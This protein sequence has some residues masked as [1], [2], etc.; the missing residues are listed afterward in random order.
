MTVLAGDGVTVLDG[1]QRMIEQATSATALPESPLLLVAIALAVALVLVV[2]RAIW[3]ISGHVV[4][5]VHELGHGFAGLLT[6]RR[7]VSIRLSGNHA[8]VTTSKGTA[9]SVPWTTFW[10]YPVPALVGAALVLAGMSGWAGAALAAATAILLLSLLFMRG[11]LAWL[12]TPLT[13]LLAAVLLAAAPDPWL[14]S[15]VVGIG[16]FLVCGAVR[17]LVNLVRGHLRGRTHDS[18]AR[19]LAQATRVPAGVWLLLFAVLIG[20]A[21]LVSGWAVASAI[22]GL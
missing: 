21:A 14:S 19:L 4:T 22:P 3:S 16:I 11:I 8:G 1:A 17:A 13:V 12:L 15:T 10:G 2:P 5:I 9:A 7:S 18:D 6:G 20:G